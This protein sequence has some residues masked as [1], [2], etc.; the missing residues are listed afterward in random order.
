M[1]FCLNVD[2]RKEKENPWLDTIKTKIAFN[3]VIE[4]KITPAANA[5]LKEAL[6]DN[7]LKNIIIVTVEYNEILP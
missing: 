3:F 5:H 1:R 7:W 2:I 4:S 6:L